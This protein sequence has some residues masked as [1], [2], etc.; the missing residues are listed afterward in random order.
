VFQ[1]ASQAQ[2]WASNRPAEHHTAYQ[3]TCNSGRPD[4]VLAISFQRFNEI[5]H[6]PTATSAQARAVC[7]AFKS[8]AAWWA[9]PPTVLG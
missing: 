3:Q 9:L 8:T 5:A 4:M 2:Q 1:R 7:R 6:M